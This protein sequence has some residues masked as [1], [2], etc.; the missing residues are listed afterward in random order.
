MPATREH[1][2]AAM[3]VVAA[4]FV[5]AACI[6]PF[7]SVQIG[8]VDAFVPV[9]QTVLSAADLLTAT[10]L[11]G[12]Y[13]VQPRRGLLAVAG[14]YLFSGAFAFLQTLSFPGGY[15]P[16]GILG[17]G[18]DTPA[19]F[20]VFWHTTFPLSILAY[21]LL[22]DKTERGAAARSTRA[23]IIATICAVLTTV[24]ALTWTVTAW[25]NHLP[26]FYSGSV[27][28]QTRFGS[29]IN[30]ALW[31]VGAATLAVLFSRRR[32]ILDMWL[33]VTLVAWMPNFLVAAVASS[34][35][36]SV[37]WYAARGFALVASCMLL[38]VLLTE[39]MV[40]YSRLA[41]ALIL[42]RRERANQLMSI[43]AATAA[44][45][46][47]I[48]SPLG[49]ITLNT[50]IALNQLAAEPPDL[51]EIDVVLKDIERASL[52][53]DSTITSIR[54]LF[55]SASNRSRMQIEDVVCQVLRLMQHDLQTN[56]ISVSTSFSDHPHAVTGN[57]AQ[58]QQVVLN[59]VKNGV[60]AMA[61]IPV[62]QRKL[63][64]STRID[65]RWIVL[66]VR[67]AG[68]GIPQHTNVFD[69]FFTTKADG[70][71]LGLAI[72][73]T[74]IDRHGGML[75]LVATGSQGTEFEVR[76]PIA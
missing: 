50:S 8:R 25:V 1:R 44:I 31:L 39:L 37:G 3:W 38:C 65:Q 46:H 16:N 48:R 13:S 63:T 9:L 34:V 62:D 74:I 66:N 6:A 43:D 18:F 72:C 76:L 21:T 73:R 14:A 52:S 40:L 19:W 68:V 22:K 17:D 70:M 61:S 69:A 59:I 54:S 12:Q 15:G 5:L 7:A 47:E 58:L 71:G 75:A 27:T 56:Q 49:S 20:F 4:L 32:T 10:L 2:R 24:A 42:Q 55:K 64:V 26:S 11:F 60:E 57:R 67:D 29:Q 35:R 30:I 51:E 28:L 53:V 33:M 23:S 45:A 41:S 36:F